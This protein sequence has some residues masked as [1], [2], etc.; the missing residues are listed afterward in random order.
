MDQTRRGFRLAVKR[1][2]RAGA[3][4][5]KVYCRDH[6]INDMPLGDAGFKPSRKEFRNLIESEFVDPDA[7]RLRLPAA[8]YGGFPHGWSN[9]SWKRMYNQRNPHDRWFNGLQGGRVPPPPPPP[10]SSS[11]SSSSSSDGGDDDDN[12]NKGPPVKAADNV[13]PKSAQARPGGK[14]VRFAVQNGNLALA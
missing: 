11:S 5:V 4:P 6:E 9:P 14:R 1:A 13:K 8:K 10:P 12:N 3:F 2:K 7:P